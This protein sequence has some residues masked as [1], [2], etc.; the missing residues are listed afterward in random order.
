MNPVLMR[1]KA[2]AFGN[3]EHPEAHDLDFVLR[4]GELTVLVG[5]QDSGRQAL[6]D[7]LNGNCAIQRGMV[8]TPEGKIFPLQKKG[9]CSGQF[10]HRGNQLSGAGGGIDRNTVSDA[11]G[12]LQ[13]TALEHR[14][15]AEAGAG[16]AGSGAAGTR[17]PG[18]REPPEPHGVLPAQSGRSSGFRR[19][20]DDYSGGFRGLFRWRTSTSWCRS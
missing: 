13:T 9:V 18:G 15:A 11:A 7:G 14:P 12:G 19:K 17:C 6:F 5:E 3:E 8:L 20:P 2:L 10:F 16:I 4:C 1:A